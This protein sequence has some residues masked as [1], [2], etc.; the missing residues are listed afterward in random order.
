MTKIL[1]VFDLEGTLSDHT[2]R[3]HLLPKTDEKQANSKDHYAAFHAEFPKDKVHKH[4]HGIY[5]VL[6]DACEDLYILTGMMEKHREMATEWLEEHGCYFDEIIMRGNDDFRPSP[7]FKLETLKK[8]WSLNRYK[9]SH[10][11]VFDDR[12]DVVAHLHKAMFVSKLNQ[13][14]TCTVQAFKVN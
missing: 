10:I 1:Y 14:V 11:I 6:S 2:H 13:R 3:L 5:N 9:W 7:E 4:I 12:E 8:I